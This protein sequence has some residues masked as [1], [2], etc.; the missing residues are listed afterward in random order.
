METVEEIYQN[1]SQRVY[2]F[3]LS[4]TNSHEL[5][6]E[7]TQ[8]T[9]FYAV[10]A[11]DKFKGNSSVLTW[12]CGIAKNLWLKYLRDNKLNED[13]LDFENVSQTISAED[14]VFIQWE[15]TEVLKLIHRLDEPIREVMYL[16]LIGELSFYQIGEI[17]GKKENWARVNFYRGKKRIIEEMNKNE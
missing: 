7:L 13:I 1:Y 9:F 2:V 3:L 12:L 8:E 5:A 16:R 17:M 6:E 4:K 11:I 14:E 15:N 10:N